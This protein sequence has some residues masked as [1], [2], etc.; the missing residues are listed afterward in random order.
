M[1]ARV[2]T[3]R[4]D[5]VTGRFDDDALVSVL[6]GQRLLSMSEHPFVVDGTPLLA[7][8]LRYEPLSDA[9][10]AEAARG[11]R[12]RPQDA[13]PEPD[14][15]L[16][17]ALRVWRNGRAKVDGRPAYVLFTNAQRPRLRCRDQRP[18]RP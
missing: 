10:R 16:F 14:H 1:P 6:E 8:V 11:H 18:V 2:V 13:L 7:L 5:A 3:V 17:E 15:A 4:F 12:P 9:G